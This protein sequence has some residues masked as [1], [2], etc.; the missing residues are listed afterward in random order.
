MAAAEEAIQADLIVLGAGM[1]GLTAASYAARHGLMVVVI[2]KQPRIGGSAV[3]SQGGLWSV[4]SYELFREIN[5]GGDP[6]LGRLLIDGYEEAL[7]WI[8]A[9]EVEVGPPR[10]LLPNQGFASTSRSVDL[11]SYLRRCEAAVLEAG[12]WV[13]TDARV[14]ALTRAD[15]RVTGVEVEDRNGVSVV[16]APHTVLATGGFQ[17]DPELRTRL[18]GP[19]TTDMLVRSNAGSTGDGLRLG[20]AAGAALSGPTDR[21]YG[22][23][24]P[25]PLTGFTERDFLPLRQVILS[26]RGILLDRA[27]QRFTDE[28]VGYYANAQ[29]VSRVPG[30]RALLVVDERIWAQNLERIVDFMGDLDQLRARGTNV[31]RGS[32][33]E[34]D[35]AAAGWGFHNTADAVVAFNTGVASESNGLAPTRG[36]YRESLSQAPYTVMEVQPA[37]TFTFGG[38]RIDPTTRVLDEAGQPIPGLL[39]AG[40][41]SGG[42]FYDG[43]GGGLSMSCVT[44]LAAAKTALEQRSP[45]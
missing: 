4:D 3:L 25:S 26:P 27:G 12:G 17:G 14:R 1:A 29:A 21:W 35:A 40:A 18:I 45:V 31:A 9:M 22:H 42:H 2:E 43:Y 7:E 5:P 30:G 34:V 32:L 28:S 37:I 6:E 11:V 8:A 13:I 19:H 36:R 10:S 38:L 23:T 16:Q 24:L 20:T 33:A 41:D 39:A 44:G 15:G